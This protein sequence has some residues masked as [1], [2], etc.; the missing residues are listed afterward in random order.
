MNEEDARR[1]LAD[2]AGI[3]F[4]P[5]VVSAFLL[6]GPL[7]ELE[8][9]AEALSDWDRAWRPGASEVRPSDLLS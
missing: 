5:K 2:W 3:E 8:S 6:L 9:F 1:H 7:A 4:D